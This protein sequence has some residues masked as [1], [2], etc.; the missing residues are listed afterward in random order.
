[1]NTVDIDTLLNADSICRRIF[2]GVFSYHT[3][4]SK[5]RLLVCN[6]NPSTKPGRHW[7]AIYV[8]EHGCGEYFG[9]FE[10]PPEKHFEDYMNE[11]CRKWVFNQKQLHSVMSSFCGYYCCMYCLFRCRGVDLNGVVNVFTNDT[12]FNDSLAHSFVRNKILENYQSNLSLLTTP[13]S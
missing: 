10:Q 9:S 5:P 2:Q 1:M 11:H 12:A 6:T 13:T 8:S 4:P 3:L 7:V